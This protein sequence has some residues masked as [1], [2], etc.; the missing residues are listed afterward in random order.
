MIVAAEGELVLAAACGHGDVV[1]VDLA[2]GNA[3]VLADAAEV[4]RLVVIAAVAGGEIDRQAR[5]PAAEREVQQGLGDAR[6]HGAAV[7]V[8]AGLDVVGLGG[9]VEVGELLGRVLADGV[10]AVDQCVLP[11]RHVDLRRGGQAERGRTAGRGIGIDGGLRR[12]LRRRLA[13]GRREADGL[14][15]GGGGGR[16]GRGRRG[17]HDGRLARPP[18][19]LQLVAVRRVGGAVIG[20]GAE[21]GQDQQGHQKTGQKMSFHVRSSVAA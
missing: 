10:V 2:V 11:A 8:V 17:D 4:R 9:L 5:L 7:G 6:V 19:R 13:R 3:V 15:R 12:G 20:I 21:D 14:R 16:F 1:A 18:C